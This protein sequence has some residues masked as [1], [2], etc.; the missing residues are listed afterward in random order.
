MATDLSW[1]QQADRNYR[2]GYMILD[3]NDP[4]NVL[5]RS[6]FPV[7]EPEFDYE[8]IGIVNNVVFS[9]GAVE[10]N[11]TIFLYYGGADKVM[12]VATLKVAK[13]ISV[14]GWDDVTRKCLVQ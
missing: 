7:L 9:C 1:R 5:Y 6:P 4:F 14:I 2:L 8:K 12:A 3:L 13:L 10:K 11:G